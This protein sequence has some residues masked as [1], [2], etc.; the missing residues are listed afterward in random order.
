LK[1]YLNII[2]N[3]KLWIFHRLQLIN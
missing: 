2:L 3:I 1:L